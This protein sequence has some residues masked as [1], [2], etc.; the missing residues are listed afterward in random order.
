[1]LDRYSGAVLARVAFAENPPVARAVSWGISFHRGEAYGWLNV[2]QNT[3]AALLGA[4]LAV[5]GFAAW[6][7]RRPAGTLGVPQAP[8]VRLGWPMAALAV[9]LMI[10]FPLMGAS[11]LAALALDWLLFRRLGW[12]RGGGSRIPAE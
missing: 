4:A 12:F 7:L 6:W 9:T 1:V 8:E 10:L 2:A 3:L 11:L 5:T